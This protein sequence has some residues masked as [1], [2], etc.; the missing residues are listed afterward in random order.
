MWLSVDVFAVKI[1]GG[2]RAFGDE[3]LGAV[4]CHPD[5]VSLGYGMPIIVQSVDAASFKDKETVFHDV[6]LN[7]GKCGAG[8]EGEDVDGEVVS[9]LGFW[10]QATEAGLG[11]SEKRGFGHFGG[12][13]EES[14]GDGRAGQGFVLFGKPHDF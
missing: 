6:D 10:N 7:E 5:Y 3:P 12:V 9:E 2:A 4:G 13:T 11:I 1:T 8:I 14:S